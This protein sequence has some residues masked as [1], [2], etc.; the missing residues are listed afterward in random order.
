VFLLVES[1]VVLFSS[2]K[3]AATS[4]AA[5]LLDSEQVPRSSRLWIDIVAEAVRATRANPLRTALAALATTA[6]VATMVVVITGLDGIAAYAR[7]S[8]ARAFGGDT[9]VITQVVPGQLSRRELADRLA[10]NPPIKAADQRFL[11]RVAGREVVYA[12][13]AQRPGD[14]V[15][16]NRR[17]EGA[18]LNGTSHRLPDIR[19]IEIDQGR[20]FTESETTR[21]APVVVIGDDIATTLFPGASALGRPVRIAGRRFEV[22]GVVARQGTAGGVTLDRYA[23]VPLG[24]WERAFG[25][26]P[27]LQLFARAPSGFS[28]TARAEARARV[29]M[30]A[31][32]QLGPGEPDTFDVLTPEAARTFVLNLAQRIGAAA[33]PITLM[34]L[35]TAIVVVT[36][37]VLVSVT[38]RTRDIGIRRALGARR[39]RIV[40]EVLAEALVTA[41]LGGAAGMA[42][43]TLALSV[44]SRLTGIALEPAVGTLVLASGAAAVTGVIA[45]LY[46]ARH[47]SNIDVI[48]ALRSE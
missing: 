21:A 25:A 39:G 4:Q 7:D 16:G 36:N 8:G 48:V 31:R 43:A 35:I 5:H 29:S 33:L 3:L 20:F 38:Q 18:A 22:I 41:C 2:R 11:E 28:G 13:V 17:F 32:R 27:S 1:A 19:V 10:R 45:G 40:A 47:A 12:P 15:A 34:S 26:A 30:R 46:P 24:A 14:V 37:T 44:A 42:M 9:F 23:Y 6:A